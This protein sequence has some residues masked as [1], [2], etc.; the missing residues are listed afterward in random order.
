MESVLVPRRSAFACRACALAALLLLA[1]VAHAAPA[2][3]TGIRGT[4]VDFETK[5]PISG[6]RVT[7][8]NLRDTTV[9][10]LAVS[11]DDGGF[12]FAT[13]P[14]GQYR[15][16]GERVG[17]LLLRQTLTLDGQPRSLG[18]LGLQSTAVPVSGVEV[19]A[20]PPAAVQN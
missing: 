1:I 11:G 13:L 8:T 19:K 14:A 15:L 12:G 18:V 20:A 2:P 6:V 5:A 3:A 7:L 9:S 17:Y 16:T 4:T 10:W